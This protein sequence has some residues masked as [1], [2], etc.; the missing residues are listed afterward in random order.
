MI[1]GS[2]RSPGGGHSNPLQYSCLGNLMDRGAWQA[3]VHGDSRNQI[4]LSDQHTRTPLPLL[5]SFLVSSWLLYVFFSP[6]LFSSFSM[7]KSYIYFREVRKEILIHFSFIQKFVI[8]EPLCAKYLKH[9]SRSDN[10]P[11]PFTCTHC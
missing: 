8:E 9:N 1:P 3:T 4:R 6:L 5:M 10:L 11:L 7:S 2:G